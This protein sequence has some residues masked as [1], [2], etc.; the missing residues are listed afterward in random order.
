M[1]YGREIDGEV[2]TF[3]TTGYTYKR[4]FVLYDR[5]PESV[6]YPHK[7]GEM[8]AVSGPA[9]GNA[10]PYL[11]E[12]DKMPLADWRKKHADSLVLVESE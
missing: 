6:W 2:T 1:V 9:A 4:T 11:A 10:L 8:N 3:G 5:K 7:P 12:P